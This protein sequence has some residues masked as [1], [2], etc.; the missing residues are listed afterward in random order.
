[1]P[2]GDIYFFVQTDV[3]HCDRGINAEEKLGHDTQQHRGACTS[4]TEAKQVRTQGQ[5]SLLTVLHSGSH[6]L[7]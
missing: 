3:S 2:T 1:M 4:K 6:C 5:A 7:T